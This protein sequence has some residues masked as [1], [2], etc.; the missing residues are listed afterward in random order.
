MTS[1]EKKDKGGLTFE[2][3][4]IVSVKD[5]KKF[6][7]MLLEGRIEQYHTSPAPGTDIIFY[8]RGIPDVHAY[9]DCFGQS[10]DTHFAQACYDYR[11]D[12]IL[13]MPPWKEIY[14]VD[15]ERFETYEESVQVY[16]S[17]EKAY[18]R[19]GYTVTL[20]P[21]GSIEER[22]DFILEHLKLV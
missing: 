11:Y 2:T 13:L 15:N 17:L 9:M 8:D 19:F 7:Q 22:T 3:N 12:A 20:V 16:E 5:P 1:A 21:K 4:P 18:T 14:A 6:N 10:Y